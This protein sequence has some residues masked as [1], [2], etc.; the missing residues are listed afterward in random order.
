MIKKLCILTTLVCC[1]A[2]FAGC[3][4]MADDSSESWAKEVII[5]FMN[6]T[7]ESE[8]NAFYDL[9]NLEFIAE[10]DYYLVRCRILSGE[11][12]DDFIKRLESHPQV[13]YIK[14]YEWDE[15]Y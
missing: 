11:S 10:Y 6:D 13:E 4:H 9:N 1:I 7:T 3:A 2:G 5:K 12:I 8:K 14:P 15:K